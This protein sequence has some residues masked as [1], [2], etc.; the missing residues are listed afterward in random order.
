V[1]AQELLVHDGCEGKVTETVHAGVVD[2]FRVLV[3]ACRG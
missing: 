2:D 1:N 3:L